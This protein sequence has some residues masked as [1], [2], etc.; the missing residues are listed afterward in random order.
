MT[1]TLTN[2]AL[3]RIYGNGRGWS[4]SQTDF[5]DLGSATTI[6]SIF[7]RLHEK[8]VIRRTLP[9]LYD[10]P[11]Y[12]ELLQEDLAPDIFQQA[13][14]IARKFKWEIHPDGASALNLMGVSTQVPAR[15]IFLSDGPTREYNILGTNI[16]FRKQAARHMKF[17]YPESGVIVHGLKSLG[18]EQIDD[19]V[20]E[21]IRRWL[22]EVKRKAVLKDTKSVADWIG[23]AIRKIC[24]EG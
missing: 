6:N 15:Y 17:K 4:F 2:K 24:R 16:W 11:Q 13:N 18:Q 20:I 12:S 7:R 10:Y 19:S 21:T 23:E 5:S 8:G 14:A 1:Q 22:P 3:S 9:G